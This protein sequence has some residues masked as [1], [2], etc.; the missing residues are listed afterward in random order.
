MN[1]I[2]Q[3]SPGGVISWASIEKACEQSTHIHLSENGAIMCI[4][5]ILGSVGSR[6][7]WGTPDVFYIHC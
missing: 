4:V 1:T 6:M 7:V 2:G 5:L 3:H